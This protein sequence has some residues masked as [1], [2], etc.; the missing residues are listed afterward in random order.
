[1]NIRTLLFC[2]IVL[3]TCS[4]HAADE[5]HLPREG[6]AT[7]EI[8]AVDDAPAWCCFGDRTGTRASCDLDD[9]HGSFSSRDDE[10]TDVLRIYARF[11]EG[12]LDRIRALAPACAV[13]LKSPAQEIDP[14]AVD[15]SARWLAAIMKSQSDTPSLTRGVRTNAMAALA[16]HRSRIAHDAL[17]DMARSDK[18]VQQRKD[19]LFWIAHLRGI[20]GARVA[21]Q[22]MFEDADPRVREHA[23]F[24]VSQSKSP[25]RAEDLI[26]LAT[27]DAKSRVRSQAWFWA[28]QVGGPQTEVAIANAL[29]NER[30]YEVRQQAVFALSQLPEN[31]SVEALIKV[32]EDS[33][34]SREDRLQ[35]L[36]WLA[37]NPSDSALDYLDRLIAATGKH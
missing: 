14:V 24:A 36:F 19:A 25:Q 28:A 30:D 26:R 27:T 33:S 11:H 35:A 10:R 18:W 5:L 29:R 17:S 21:T 16:A 32:A 7:W 8:P 37:Q 22:V 31:R 9:A 20:E 34:L 4:A 1:M 6:W 2:T 23:A 13:E 3:T 15:V 12:R